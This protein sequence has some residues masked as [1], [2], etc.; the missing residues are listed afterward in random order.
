MSK[1]SITLPDRRQVQ[2]KSGKVFPKGV[3]GWALSPKKNIS[4]RG[5]FVRTESSG[6]DLKEYIL[7]RAKDGKWSL[8]PEGQKEPKENTMEFEIKKAIEVFE[9]QR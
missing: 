8:D 2:V 6:E 9:S 7:Y 4:K 5:Y 1:F 3:I